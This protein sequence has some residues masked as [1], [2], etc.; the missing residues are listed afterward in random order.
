MHDRVACL[1]KFQASM[2]RCALII[3]GILSQA[4]EQMPA[5]VNIV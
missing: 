5:K 3:N 4:R 2:L 1:Q